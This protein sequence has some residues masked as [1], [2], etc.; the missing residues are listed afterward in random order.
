MC[1][2]TGGELHDDGY[3]CVL[4]SDPLYC[5]F[6]VDKKRLQLLKVMVYGCAQIAETWDATDS[7]VDAVRLVYTIYA[8]GKKDVLAGVLIG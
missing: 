1:G 3:Q 5:I 7:W 8:Q 2:L 4:L 6:I